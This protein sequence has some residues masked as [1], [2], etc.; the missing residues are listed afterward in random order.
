MDDLPQE[1]DF[2][3]EKVVNEIW[4]E[5]GTAEKRGQP[6]MSDFSGREEYG[7]GKEFGA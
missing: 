6:D 5:K 7:L 1:R 4:G 3:M 2:T